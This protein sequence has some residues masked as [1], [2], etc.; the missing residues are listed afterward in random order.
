MLQA[1]RPCSETRMKLPIIQPCNY[2]V[3]RYQ[4]FI[5][6]LATYNFIS[7]VGIPYSEHSSFLELKR[8][9]QFI[10]PAKIIP[11]VFGAGQRISDMQAIFKE[12]LRN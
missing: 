2:M 1:I 3:T 12:W 9:V 5:F 8:F 11:T 7:T 6:I 4:P 10:R